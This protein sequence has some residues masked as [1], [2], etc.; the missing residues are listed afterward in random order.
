MTTSEFLLWF[1][2]PVSL[3]VAALYGR[4]RGKIAGWREAE[5]LVKVLTDQ[6]VAKVEARFPCTCRED[7][8]ADA[9]SKA[10]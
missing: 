7:G 3:A 6:T 4:T 1:L 2:Y 8:N 9:E 10:R 5:A